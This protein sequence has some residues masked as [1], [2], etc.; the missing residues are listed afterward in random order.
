MKQRFAPEVNRRRSIFGEIDHGP[1]SAILNQ[2]TL[3]GTDER[4]ALASL[5][6]HAT[7]C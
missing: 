3:H 7:L 4:L 2:Q 6:L 1:A 5:A